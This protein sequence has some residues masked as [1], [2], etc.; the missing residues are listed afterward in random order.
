MANGDALIRVGSTSKVAAPAYSPRVNVTGLALAAAMGSVSIL[1]G[2]GVAVSGR[3]ATVSQGTVAVT[4]SSNVAPTGQ[5]V[6]ASVGVVSFTGLGADLHLRVGSTAAI[7]APSFTSGAAHSPTG[8]SLTVSQGT[9]TPSVIN[10]ANPVGQQMVADASGAGVDIDATVGVDGIAMTASQ[11]TASAAGV[12]G[13]NSVFPGGQ[14]LTVSQGTTTF[15]ADGFVYPSGISLT[16]QM[17][18]GG[19]VQYPNAGPPWTPWMDGSPLV[20]V[21]NTQT[22]TGQSITVSQGT[23][24]IEVGSSQTDATV[25]V[26]GMELTTAQGTGA[27]LNSHDPVGFGLTASQGTALI[28]VDDSHTAVGDTMTVGQGIA[29]VQA[30]TAVSPSGM[31]L[32]TA[33]GTATTSGNRTVTVTGF[34]LVT[35]MGT[36][37]IGGPDLSRPL[38]C[39]DRSHAVYDLRDDSGPRYE[40]TPLAHP[41]YWIQEVTM[42]RTIY[43][44]NDDEFEFYVTRRNSSTGDVEPATS[45]AGMTC[46][47]SASKT[48]T[49]IHANLSVSAAERSGAP[50]Y[51]YG[52]MQGSDIATQLATYDGK[53]VYRQLINGSDIVAYTPVVVRSNRPIA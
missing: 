17:T 41:R 48:G 27:V 10:G 13:N 26:G 31:E 20:V 37:T 7:T 21:T 24:L 29:T 9:V 49:A 42:A 25:P 5:S 8:Q 30:S 12:G 39:A 19:V 38:L 44:N 51:Y 52:V 53:T 18:A 50:G 35:S 43:F 2:G 11:G 33:Q 45:I 46:R 23:P 14:S 16:A 1:S 40:V 6:T 32:T 15:P 22:P 36:V 28:V 4:A 47:I 3:A 34:R